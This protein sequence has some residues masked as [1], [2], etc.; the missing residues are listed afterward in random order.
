MVFD[1]TAHMNNL[2]KK[3]NINVEP[4]EV[5]FGIRNFE[6]GYKSLNI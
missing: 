4:S 6:N 3:N 2:T 5:F 1:K